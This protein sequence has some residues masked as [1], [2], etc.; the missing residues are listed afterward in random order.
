MASDTQTLEVPELDNV[1]AAQLRPWL[2]PRAVSDADGFGADGH[3]DLGLT[4]AIVIVSLAAIKALAPVLV[5]QKRRRVIKKTDAYVDA[6]GVQH[7]VVTEF[8]FEAEWSEAEV[9]KAL[10]KATDVD[11]GPLLRS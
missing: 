3:G 10:G 2:A 5:R 6:D 4:A 7:S 9:I 8:V 11:V 1:D